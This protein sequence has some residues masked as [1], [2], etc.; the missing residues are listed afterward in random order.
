M[1]SSVN[2]KDIIRALQDGMEAAWDLLAMDDNDPRVASEAIAR[3]G[4]AAL[5]AAGFAVVRTPNDPVS[6]QCG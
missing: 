5:E 6:R 4:L 1:N 3:A 2:D